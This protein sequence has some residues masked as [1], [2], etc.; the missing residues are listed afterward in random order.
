MNIPI[1]LSFPFVMR[2]LSFLVKQ[3]IRF[4][5]QLCNYSLEKNSNKW[6]N[7]AI[8]HSFEFSIWFARETKCE[9]C[10]IRSN[11]KAF[12]IISI[13]PIATSYFLCSVKHRLEP[14]IFDTVLGKFIRSPQTHC[15]NLQIERCILSLGLMRRCIMH[16]K[17]E[18]VFCRCMNY[19]FHLISG[20]CE[21][22]N[23]LWG[24]RRG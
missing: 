15:R 1:W 18:P 19:W 7:T 16:I 17:C 9:S 20:S 23:G 5:L 21:L 24:V 12:E 11:L 13:L 10:K 2:F 8:N 4:E 14:H 3:L 6:K 22:R